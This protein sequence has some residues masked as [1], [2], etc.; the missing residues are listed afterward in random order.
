[1]SKL[2]EKSHPEI[3]STTETKEAPVVDNKADN[4]DFYNQ[5]RS[6]PEEAKKEIK[7]GRIKGFTNI[8]PMWRIKKLTEMFG[9]VGIGWYYDIKKTWFEPAGESAIAAFVEIHLFYKYNDEWSMPIQGIGGSMLVKSEQGGLYS[10][11]ECLKMALTDALSVVCKAIGIG[12]DVYWHEDMRGKYSGQYDDE[13]QIPPDTTSQTPT[14]ITPTPD[15]TPLPELYCEKF[16]TVAKGRGINAQ[17]A[18]KVIAKW[19]GVQS[20]SQL[21]KKN[22]TAVCTWFLNVTAQDVKNYLEEVAI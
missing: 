20:A 10:N 9:P 17:C 22:Y 5:V 11:D 7:G 1:M 2:N 4:L 13:P 6:V 18:N 21:T 16:Y 14:N 3:E 12:A 15:S 8:N 19:F